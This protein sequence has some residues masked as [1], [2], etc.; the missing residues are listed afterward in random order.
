MNIQIII[1]EKGKH[2][3]TGDLNGFDAARKFII[4][5]ELEHDERKEDDE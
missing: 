4:Q 3:A 2:I 1:T 5:Q